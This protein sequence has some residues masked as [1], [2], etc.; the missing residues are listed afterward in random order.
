[1]RATALATSRAAPPP[2]PTMA[3]AWWAR[4]AAAPAATWLSTGLPATS[5][6]RAGSSPA[7]RRPS[8]ISPGRGSEARPLSVTTSGRRAPWAARWGPVSLRTPGPNWMRV[9]KLKV[10]MG[11]FTSKLNHL[12]VA[13]Q[14]PVRDRVL[15]L[16]PLPLARADVV[17]HELGAQDL[18]G[19]A[20]LREP[21]RGLL[22]RAR[23]ADRLLH[24]VGAA[25]HG[26]LLQGKL[27]LHAPQAGPDGGGQGEVGVDVGPGDAHLDAR[28]LGPGGDHAE[29]DGAVVDPPGDLR[30]RPVAVH[31]PLVAVRV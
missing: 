13:A 29:G 1:M 21:P 9:G 20:R 28:G 2:R 24:H 30:R 17:V 10:G 31:D 4:Q 25:L 6:N 12:E 23:E 26:R 11:S 7:A 27:V 22:Q 14:L 3:S 16:P 18:A 19:Q 5:A 15:E 8:R